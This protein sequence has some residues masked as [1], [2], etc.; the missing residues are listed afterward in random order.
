MVLKCSQ[1]F[2]LPNFTYYFRHF[3]QEGEDEAA[4]AEDKAKQEAKEAEL[5]ARTKK[6]S[7]SEEQTEKVSTLQVSSPVL[8][9]LFA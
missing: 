3:K 9:E 2:R 1:C 6:I 7:L 8:V 4:A 5:L